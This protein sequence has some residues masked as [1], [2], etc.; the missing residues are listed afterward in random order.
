VLDDL[1]FLL[2]KKCRSF[3]YTVQFPV[4]IVGVK[5][6]TDLYHFL[7]CHL[8]KN[9]KIA[10]TLLREIKGLTICLRSE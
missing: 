5:V 8:I 10:F 3:Q 6:K 4:K 7:D 2:I 1:T 9:N